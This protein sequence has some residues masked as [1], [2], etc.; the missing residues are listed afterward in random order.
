MS[1]R[2]ARAALAAL[3]LLAAPAARAAPPGSPWGR[4][5]FPDVELV[6]HDGRKVRFYSDLVEGKRVV[7]QFVY[8][9]CTRICGLATA[10]LARVQR[11]LG[12]AGR[13]IHL[14]SVSLDP[15]HDTPEVLRAYAAAYKARPGWTFLTG[16]KA[17][18]DLLRKKLGDLSPVEDHAPVLSVGNDVTGQWWTTRSLDTPRYLATVIGGFMDPAWDGRAAVTARAYA[19][20]PAV[21]RQGRGQALFRER[22]A[23]CHVAGGDSVGPDLAGVTARRDGG[24]LERWIRSPAALVA[25]RDPEALALVARHG[26]VEM[27]PSGLSDEELREVIAFLRTRDA[28]AAAVS[29]E[30]GRPNRPVKAAAGGDTVHP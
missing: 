19:D 3:A 12:D 25:A 11:E 30:H 28:A 7:I 4:A 15:E 17:D 16:R 2:L 13:G 23:A 14:Y 29:H 6:T 20:A 8:T 21:A 1:P 10:N 18:V 9:R 26:G 5:Y 24:W 27:P 22:C